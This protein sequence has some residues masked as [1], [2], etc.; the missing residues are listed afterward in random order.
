MVGNI[1]CTKHGTIHHM[2][3]DTIAAFKAAGCSVYNDAVSAGL[4]LVTCLSLFTHIAPGYCTANL[5]RRFSLLVGQVLLTALG[6]A[7]ARANKTMSAASKLVST[8]Q[9]V[10][11]VTK[12]Q[13]FDKAIAVK[14]GIRACEESQSQGD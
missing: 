5:P 7:P 12:G 1:R 6:T 14:C 11:I 2:Q 4:K 8:H 3:S 13:K 10:L 9:N